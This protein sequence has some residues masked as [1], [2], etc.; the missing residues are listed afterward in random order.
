MQRF[1]YKSWPAYPVRD[2]W[3]AYLFPPHPWCS[4]WLEFHGVLHASQPE[5]STGLL[6]PTPIFQQRDWPWRLALMSGGRNVK[7]AK[8][9]KM[10]NVTFACTALS[11]LFWDCCVHISFCVRK[12]EWVKSKNLIFYTYRLEAGCFVLC[13]F[14]LE[15]LLWLWNFW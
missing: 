10:L 8:T 12:R 13:R 1:C 9:R 11:A 3:L 6:S 14:L 7:K 5:T 2:Y 4:L 15:S